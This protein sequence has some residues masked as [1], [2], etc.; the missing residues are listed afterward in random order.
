MGRCF[1]LLSVGT[2]L[3][4]LGCQP[5][6]P[7]CETPASVVPS[8]YALVE[9]RLREKTDG[10]PEVAISDTETYRA[11]Y[12]RYTAAAL[13]LPDSCLKKDVLPGGDATAGPSSL[14]EEPCAAWVVELERALTNA[15]FRL[16]AWDAVLKLEREKNLSTYLAAKE[17]GAEL[18]FVL[19]DVNVASTT[20]SSVKLAKHEYFESDE[21][22]RRGK[23]L[24]FDE[25]TRSAFLAYTLDAAR[26]SIQPESVVALT[27]SLDSTAIVTQ[28]GESIWFYRRSTALATQAK[29]GLK[30]LFGRVAGGGWTPAAP[31]AEDTNAVKGDA[32][33][34]GPSIATSQ[35]A[36]DGATEPDRAELIRAGAEHFVR[37]FKSGKVE[38]SPSQGGER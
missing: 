19:N 33:N 22:G 32:P 31:V 24:T 1:S 21:Q 38:T 2:T 37:S 14:L 8:E 18:V 3:L 11:E 26:K 4:A 23:P 12:A 34:A 25:Q 20:A 13:R 7:S 16:T 27:A 28:T 30:L 17:L 15:G 9:Y 29:Q 10:A 35:P 5:A 36:A 6:L